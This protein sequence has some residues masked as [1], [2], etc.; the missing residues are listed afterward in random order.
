MNKPIKHSR[1]NSRLILEEMEQ[2]RLFSAGAEGLIASVDEPGTDPLY[3]DLDAGKQADTETGSALAAEEQS[4]EVVFIDAG[5]DNYQMLVDD[6]RANMDSSRDLEVLVLDRDRDGIE[7]ISQY[8]KEYKDL[9]AVHIISH[10]S[11]GSIELG[12]TRLDSD[13]LEANNLSIALWAN[14]FTDI[15]DILIYG[16]DL[17]ATETGQGLIDELGALTL[18]DVAASDDLTGAGSQGGDWL[19]EYRA[20][21]VESKIAVS[22]DL[23]QDYQHTLA[24]YTVTTLA[25]SGAGSLR[26]AIIDANASGTD[27]TIEF[28][29]SGTITL[30]TSGLPTISDK[31]NIDATTAPGY[32]GEPLITLDGSAT[33]STTNGFRVGP[34]AD[35]SSISGFA[36]VN[37]PNTGIRI[38]PGA[39]N[40][41]ITDNWIGTTGTGT[42]GDGNLSHGIIVRG[43][44]TIITGNVITNNGGDG[45]E[46]LDVGG[47]GTVIQGNIIG[48]DPD[49]STGTG[50]AMAGIDLQGDAHNSIVGGTGAGEGNIISANGDDGIQIDSSGNIIQGNYIGTDI[51]GTL[52]RGNGDDGIDILVN[53]SNNLIGG[54]AAGAGNLVAYTADDGIDIDGGSSN[55]FLGNQVYASVDNNFEINPAANN[56]QVAPVLAS[57]EIN[58]VGQI[59]IAGTLTS[60][61]NSYYRIEFFGKDGAFLGFANVATDGSGIA[62]FVANLSVDV[63]NGT[64]VY[65][66][67]TAS[68]STYTT[69]TDTSSSSTSVSAVRY[70]PYAF[71]DPGDYSTEIQNLDPLGYWRLGDSAGGATDLG[72]AG[73]TGTYSG[74]TLEQAGGISGDTDTAAYFDGTDYVEIQHDDAYLIDEG[75]IQAWF[76]VDDPAT[77]NL[78]HIF[79]KDSSNFDTGG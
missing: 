3:A 70:A 61:P 9:D 1:H 44:N 43:A 49:G 51:T 6:I 34:D 12:N 32:A 17:A 37:F 75:T 35:G 5:V 73:N 64:D 59:D 27:D 41:S 53:G 4:H 2:R 13:S 11:D 46:V 33:G 30:G 78:Q 71:D 65:A 45:I 22:A 68:D 66:T 10:G 7:Q 29:V 20:G 28:A 54:T 38:E 74:V 42:T 24:T 21:T 77:G 56:G 16:C 55:T 26:Q 52:N 58:T 18:T 63:A 67:A 48:L 31:V 57:A 62:N 40:V 14:A 76:N 36:I 19:L 25:D 79:S 39:D 47:T 72:S 8:L 60:A 23:Q 50:N 69:F 15:G